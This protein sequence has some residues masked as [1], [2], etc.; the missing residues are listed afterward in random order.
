M[1]SMNLA[2]AKVHLNAIVDHVEADESG[3]LLPRYRARL[4]SKYGRMRW[5]WRSVPK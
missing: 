1:E 4:R 3:G 2:D 5:S